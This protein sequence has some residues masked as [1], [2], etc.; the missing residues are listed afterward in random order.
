MVQTILIH[1]H[2]IYIE[3]ENFNYI[4][5]IDI[6]RNYSQFFFFL[7]GGGGVGLRGDSFGV[8]V[9]DDKQDTETPFSCIENNIVRRQF[10]I[11]MSIMR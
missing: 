11:C 9:S 4:L 8:L 10:K 2:R 1:C 6:L 5:D 3:V 7:G